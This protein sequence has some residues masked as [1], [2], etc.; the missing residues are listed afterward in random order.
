MAVREAEH[1]VVRY[2]N[3]SF[4]GASVDLPILVGV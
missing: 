3:K 2:R 1:I 4:T